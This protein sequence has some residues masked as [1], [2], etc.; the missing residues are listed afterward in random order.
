MD[1]M[2]ASNGTGALPAPS[3]NANEGENARGYICVDV[4]TKLCIALTL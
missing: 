1:E 3:N 4:F 2:D